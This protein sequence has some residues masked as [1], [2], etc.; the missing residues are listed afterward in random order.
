MRKA[1]QAR[2][3]PR[4]ACKNCGG[5]AQ[6][7]QPKYGQ[8]GPLCQKPDCQKARRKIRFKERYA[9]DP[10]Y[11]EK[12]RGL[13]LA[14]QRKKRES[15]KEERMRNQRFCRLCGLTIRSNN[16]VG[17]CSREGSCGR[18]AVAAHFGKNADGSCR[19]QAKAAYRRKNRVAVNRYQ[20]LYDER[21]KIK[22]NLLGARPL[23]EWLRGPPKWKHCFCECCGIPLGRRP[24]RRIAPDGITRCAKHCNYRRTKCD[25]TN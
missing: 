5:P 15:E 7:G 10:A 1:G 13:S 12:V 2:P 9:S 3:P 16:A 22:R 17:I 24:A 8:Y 23:G 19:K 6:A 11:G 14:Y 4:K 20:L 21:M 18:Q 25:T